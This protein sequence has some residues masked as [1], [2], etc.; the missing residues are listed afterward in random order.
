VLLP[1]HLA[2]ALQPPKEVVEKLLYFH[3]DTASILMVRR[4]VKK[5]S[6]NRIPRFRRKKDPYPTQQANQG[7]GILHDVSPPFSAE[8]SIC[9][10]SAGFKSELKGDELGDTFSVSTEGSI[11]DRAA[12]LCGKPEPVAIARNGA[13]SMNWDLLS[14]L[15][16]ANHFF[17]LHIACLYRASPAVLQ[18]LIHA[19]PGGA[20]A[21]TSAWGMLPIHICAA[22]VALAPPI[23]LATALI[24]L[25][26][27]WDVLASLELLAK[28]YP[29]GLVKASV[30][31][32][33][34]PKDYIEETMEEGPYRRMC[35]DVVDV[36]AVEMSFSNSNGV[37]GSTRTS[38]SKD[39]GFS[40]ISSIVPF[41]IR[42]E[43]DPNM[44]TRMV[45]DNEWRVQNPMYTLLS[46]EDWEGT[47]FRLTLEPE[48]ACEWQY[49][50]EMDAC[51]EPQLWKQLPI[52]HACRFGAPVGLICLLHEG[53]P[54]GIKSRDPYTGT[55]ALH[56]A[57]RY[58][59]S[60]S[61]I[62]ALVHHYPSGTKVKNHAGHL[63]LHLACMYN[64]SME[65]IHF[66]VKVYPGS[67]CE[68]DN[69]GLTPLDYAKKEMTLE[70]ETV[71]LL[72]RLSEFMI[73]I[74]NRQ[75]SVLP[76]DDDDKDELYIFEDQGISDPEVEDLTQESLPHRLLFTIAE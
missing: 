21:P 57:C 22:G 61:V 3:T 31:N 50:I 19:F 35:L 9:D 71:N 52:H 1:I 14:L 32:G 23:S 8:S 36:V 5:K 42:C 43:L 70:N 25:V 76:N 16:E 41:E 55:L 24:P 59:A 34:T 49:G 67:I 45:D 20:R 56:H 2:C 10:S 75:N 11:R 29:E 26:E 74:N 4:T 15:K 60:R 40:D 64:T 39:D 68:C 17:P 37:T 51:N 6:L 33:M 12:H 62:E 44:A 46:T 53:Y 72:E 69:K 27:E 13:P 30:T 65:V 58:K 48:Q 63:P 54:K 47:A 73:R 38:T 66:L 28:V 18:A 7:S